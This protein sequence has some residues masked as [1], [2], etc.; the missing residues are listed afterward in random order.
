M[1]KQKPF[2][3]ARPYV[4]YT[5]GVLTAQAAASR[6]SRLEFDI[7]RLEREIEIVESRAVRSRRALR[8]AVV[9]RHA[10]LKIIGRPS[11]G[12]KERTGHAT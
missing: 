10:L 3:P 9:Q 12:L 8:A 2:S 5:A 6:L 1:R 4:S 11:P 7:A